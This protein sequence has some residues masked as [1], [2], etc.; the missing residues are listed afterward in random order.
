[1]KCQLLFDEC[2]PLAL[3]QGLRRQSPNSDIAQVGEDDA[4]IKGTTDAELL[5]FCETQKW[6][7]VSGDRSTLAKHLEAHRAEGRKTYGV[8]V[9]SRGYPY[10]SVIDDLV[11]IL[12]CSIAEEW[13]NDRVYLPSL[14]RW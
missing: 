10:A 8:A 7:F 14:S 6:F 2:V 11:L 1:M 12:E 3:I 5:V 13:I 4:P 9:I